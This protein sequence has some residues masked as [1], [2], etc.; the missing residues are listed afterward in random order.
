VSILKSTNSGKYGYI[1]FCL[2]GDK[3]DHSKDD[4]NYYYETKYFIQPPF[5]VTDM[6]LH[7]GIVGTNLGSGFIAN[8]YDSNGQEKGIRINTYKELELVEFF[9]DMLCEAHEYTETLV[10]HPICN[11]QLEFLAKKLE[12]IGEKNKIILNSV[13]KKYGRRRF[14]RKA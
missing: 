13:E 10:K 6:S 5:Y 1:K 7:H 14:T 3:Y 2:E 12:E 4:I 8:I 9:W 11:I